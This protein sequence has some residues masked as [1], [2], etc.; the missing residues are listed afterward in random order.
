MFPA[1]PRFD[2]IRMTDMPHVTTLVREFDPE[3]VADMYARN[4]S[5][6]A[7]AFEIPDAGLLQ[8]LQDASTAQVIVAEFSETIIGAAVLTFPA[9]PEETAA[10]PWFAREDLAV[11]SR[12]VVEHDMQGL[13]VASRML[14]CADRT[15]ARMGAAGIGCGILGSSGDLLGPFERRGFR[16]AAKFAREG[17]KV[18][19]MHK[20]LASPES[21]AA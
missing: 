16:P 13:G 15:A 3:A 6:G 19:A 14:E 20:P 21:A 11:L 8:R 1:A 17:D 12:L 4:A 9:L 18:I 5:P 2:R 7:Y 10:V